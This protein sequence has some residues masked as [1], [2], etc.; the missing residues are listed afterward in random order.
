[1]GVR[2]SPPVQIKGEG[3]KEVLSHGLKTLKIENR[4]KFKM[5]GKS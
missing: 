1:M 3:E 4:E 2:I 5:D